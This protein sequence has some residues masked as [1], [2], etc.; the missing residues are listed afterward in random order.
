MHVSRLNPLP[1]QASAP[2]DSR[3]MRKKQDDDADRVQPIGED[4]GSEERRRQQ[5][6]LDASLEEQ[7]EA[8]ETVEGEAEEFYQASSAPT[9]PDGSEMTSR[10]Q[11]EPPAP[12]PDS[13]LDQLL[14]GIKS[15][16]TDETSNDALVID[17]KPSLNELLSHILEKP[18]ET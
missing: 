3:L 7:P 6:W 2:V 10:P 1:L 18:E 11:V 5:A 4:D 15:E 17:P 13:A 8:E 14:A 16:E 9:L 12:P